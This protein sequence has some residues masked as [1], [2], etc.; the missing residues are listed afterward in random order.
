[1]RLDLEDLITTLRYF[2]DGVMAVE[3]AEERFRSGYLIAL[4]STKP[5]SAGPDFMLQIAPQK[6]PRGLG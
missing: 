3:A 5:S 4:K 1:M 6:L 2:R